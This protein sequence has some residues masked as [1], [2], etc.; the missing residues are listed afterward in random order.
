MRLLHRHRWLIKYNLPGDLM[1]RVCIKKG[2]NAVQSH[3]FNYDYAR[4]GFEWVNGNFITDDA[5]PIYILA[6]NYEEFLVAK[7][8]LTNRVPPMYGEQIVYVRDWADI[9]GQMPTILFFGTWYTNGIL[10][11]PRINMILN[12]RR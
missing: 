9:L 6:G 10:E 5:R 12:K 2:C 1:V 4:P 3:M 7:Q 8:T 11:D